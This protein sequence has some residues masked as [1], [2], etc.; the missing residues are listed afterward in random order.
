VSDE[1][2]LSGSTSE[3]ETLGPSPE[4]LAHLARPPIST[5]T[6]ILNALADLASALVITFAVAVAGGLLWFFLLD[7]RSGASP[8][9]SQSVGLIAFATGVQEIVLAYFAWRRIR[10]NYEEGRAPMILGGARFRAILLGVLCGVLLIGFG[11]LI[12]RLV[13]GV[14]PKGVAQLLAGLLH[15]SWIAAVVFL[16][17][18][19]V[20]PVSEEYFFRGAI[21]GLARANANPWAGGIVASLLFAILHLNFR[22][23]P[24]YLIFSSMNCWLMVRTKTLA[25]PIAAHVTVNASACIAILVA[26]PAGSA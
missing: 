12:A 17:I 5:R 2:Q 15:R 23:V 25:A 7:I 26:G 8:R 14:A 1:G 18:A 24:Y 13:G 20:A 9:P 21:F 22:M 4:P 3:A 11:A 19:I 10:K 6:V 16:L